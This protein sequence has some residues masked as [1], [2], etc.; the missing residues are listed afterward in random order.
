MENTIVCSS[1]TLNVEETAESSAD[2]HKAWDDLG[3]L[4]PGAK[5]V[6]VLSNSFREMTLIL[7]TRT[8]RFEATGLATPGV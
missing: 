4:R 7:H 1:K 6:S 2:G 8:L 3:G 5:W